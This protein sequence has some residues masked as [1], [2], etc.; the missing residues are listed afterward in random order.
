MEKIKL[1]QLLR[2]KGNRYLGN[3]SGVF[4]EGKLPDRAGFL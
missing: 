3:H 1:G 2:A 4:R